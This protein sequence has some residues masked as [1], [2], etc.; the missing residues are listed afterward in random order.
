MYSS[1]LKIT[2]ARMQLSEACV[3]E[4]VFLVRDGIGPS[5]FREPVHQSIDNQYEEDHTNIVHGTRFNWYVVRET[6]HN[7]HKRRPQ[8]HDDVTNQSKSREPERPMLNL[9]PSF[10]RETDDGNTVSDVL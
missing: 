3:C 4:F 1:Y 5:P 9:A 10:D 8:D 2:R 7:K 6:V